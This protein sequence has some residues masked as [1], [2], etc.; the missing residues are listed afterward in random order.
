MDAND[1]GPVAPAGWVESNGMDTFH[2]GDLLYMQMDVTSTASAGTL[3]GA[4]GTF[5]YDET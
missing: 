2:I 5:V 3:A 4:T 1:Q